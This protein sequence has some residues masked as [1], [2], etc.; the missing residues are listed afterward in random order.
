MDNLLSPDSKLNWA[1][2]QKLKYI[3][4]TFP[5]Q[6]YYYYA[7]DLTLGK[8]LTVAIKSSVALLIFLHF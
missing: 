4:K 8:Q 7:H 3:Q 6:I 5:S 2:A 1:T